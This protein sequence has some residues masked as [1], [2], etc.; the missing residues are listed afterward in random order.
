MHLRGV[1]IGLSVLLSA[2]ASAGPASQVPQQEYV[3]VQGVAS[4]ALAPEILTADIVIERR[5]ESSAKLSENANRVAQQI[6][7]FL[8]NKGV[9]EK[10]IQS[11]QAN[12]HPRYEY[13]EQRQVQRGYSFSRRISVKLRNLEQ[14]PA[15]LDGVIT[16]GATR[17]QNIQFSLAQPEDAYLSALDN[18]LLDARKRAERIAR[19]LKLTLGE[20]LSVDELSSYSPAP[21]EMRERAFA[22][23]ESSGFTPGQISTSARVEVRFRLSN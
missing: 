21:M 12:L 1:L 9:E 14:Y 6:I 8:L 20:V 7:D 11:L 17:L 2:C 19:T 22:V 5:G 4:T 15:I 10:D 16:L 23:D 13:I 3:R 18:A